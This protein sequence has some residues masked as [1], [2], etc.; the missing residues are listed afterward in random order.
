MGTE[1]GFEVFS[2]KRPIPAEWKPKNFFGGHIFLHISDSI[3]PI[4]S[5]NNRFDP[6]AD[7]HNDVNFMKI[8]SKLRPEYLSL[9]ND[10]EM[11]T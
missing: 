10:N 5:K 6:C 11:L 8:G 3:G 9:E 7:L 4:V 1:Y 2:S